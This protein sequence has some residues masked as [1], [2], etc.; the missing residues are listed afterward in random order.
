MFNKNKFLIFSVI[1]ITVLAVFLNGCKKDDDDAPAVATTIEKLDD[2]D[3]QTATVET[4][5]SNPIVVIV[6]DQYEKAFA[7][8]DV[9]FATTNGSVSTATVKTDTEGKASVTWTLGLT[10]GIQKLTASA[11]GITGSSV[12]F[13]ATGTAVPAA[14]TIEIES[15]DG[16]IVAIG[17]DL[18]N[19]IVVIV[20]D[21]KG[22]AFKGAEVTFT[23][24]DGGSVTPTQATT[25]T[26]GKATV[27]W[28]LGKKVGE[29]K[30][31]VSTSGVLDK[32]VKA[33]SK[34]FEIGEEYAGGYI[35][36]LLKDVDTG[37]D[38]DVQHGLVCAKTDQST[39][40]QWYAGIDVETG[41]TARAVLTGKANTEKIIGVQKRDEEYAARIC[42]EYDDGT[43][44]DWFLPSK[45]ELELMYDNLHN[46]T[47]AI[48]GFSGYFYWSSTEHTDSIAWYLYLPNGFIINGYNKSLAWGVRAVRAF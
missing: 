24:S 6:K 26:D 31:T 11:T 39:E 13:S 19:P 5:L 27:T 10:I 7:G 23:A 45:D 38:K 28:K 1:I 43:Y 3:N 40:I 47:P 18:T 2:G 37:Y 41:A 12:T 22:V 32:E 16:Q 44:S 15:G 36:Y 33:T 8:A 29:Q 20:K 14:T 46:Q 34:L 35:F 48:G 42:D 30:L 21:Q 4:A 25:D 9:T 17:N